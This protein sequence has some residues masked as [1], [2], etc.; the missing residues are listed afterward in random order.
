[1]IKNCFAKNADTDTTKR[2]LLL[3]TLNL[4]TQL[5][6][7]KVWPLGFLKQSAKLVMQNGTLVHEDA[8][9]RIASIKLLM[10]IISSK[11]LEIEKHKE[12]FFEIM[13]GT[14]MPRQIEMESSTEK[15]K[16]EADIFEELVEKC[17]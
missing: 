1:M 15:N 2:N 6:K 7:A 12:E 5:V 8:D 9:I 14:D 4:F 3:K 13:F 16:L 11:E 17:N 10:E